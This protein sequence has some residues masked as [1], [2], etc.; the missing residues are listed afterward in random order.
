MIVALLLGISS[1]RAQSAAPPLSLI[2]LELLVDLGVP[3]DDIVTLGDKL[4]W[5]KDLESR[6]VDR[7]LSRLDYSFPRLRTRLLRLRPELSAEGGRLSEH[8]DI[9]NVTFPDAD[10]Q[11]LVPRNYSPE[12]EVAVSS[13]L[14]FG[15]EAAGNWRM[16][17]GFFVWLLPHSEWSFGLDEVWFWVVQQVVERQMQSLGFERSSQPATMSADTTHRQASFRRLVREPLTGQRRILLTVFRRLEDPARLVVFGTLVRPD[18]EA[19]TSL[20]DWTTNLLRMASSVRILR[21][22]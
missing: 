13:S 20:R 5:P 3:D 7:F 9:T 10:V 8:Y 17:R 14:E 2:E 19:T 1:T 11:F 22:R 6:D 4:E 12:R 16:G 21:D 18:D 15:D